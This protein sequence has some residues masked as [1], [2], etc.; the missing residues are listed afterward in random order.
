MDWL[1]L[2]AGFAA[3][4][5][6]AFLSSGCANMFACT[7]DARYIVRADGSSETYYSSCKEQ[8]GLD[9]DIDPKSGKVHVKVDKSGTQ[10]AVIAAVLQTQLQ[11]MRMI[12]LLSTPKPPLAGG[13]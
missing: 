1:K 3:L 10:E 7:T 6:L 4:A 9:A 13:S 11:L 2:S 12:E 5:A 8:I